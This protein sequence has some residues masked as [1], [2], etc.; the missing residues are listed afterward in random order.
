MANEQD[1]GQSLYT[2]EGT[3]ILGLPYERLRIPLKPDREG[4]AVATL[5]RRI[6]NPGSRRCILMVHGL[7]DYFFQTH[8]VDALVADGWNVYGIDLRK[9]GRSLLDHQTPNFC[10]SLADY[11]PELNIALDIMEADGGRE[12][13]VWGHSTGGLIASMWAHS[14]RNT[15][16]LGG[17]FLNSPFF[18]LN[19]PW[20][21]RRPLLDAL[22][23]I[24]RMRPR[25]V[26][27]Q[28]PSTLFAEAA[29][30]SLGGEWNY[31]LT[32]KPVTGFPIT[33][34]WLQAVR[35]AQNRLRA[36]LDLRIPVLVGRSLASYQPN[37]MPISEAAHTDVV[38]N[39]E[40]ISRSAISLGRNITIAQFQDAMHDLTLSELPVRQNVLDA[41]IQWA[42]IWL[43]SRP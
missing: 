31:D 4:P 41:V 10:L 25:Q 37:T 30:T 28:A 32:L 33:L 18:D 20:L 29:H 15:G 36:G 23:P 9:Y 5:I 42:S 43:P 24:G 39:V 1:W 17:L 34:G 35:S 26:I 21:I 27:P 16:R 3:D 40:H 13:L 38:L 12:V 22:R 11:F 14:H 19:L 7:A 8:V 2:H 6:G